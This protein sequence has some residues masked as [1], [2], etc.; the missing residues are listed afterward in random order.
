[1]DKKDILIL[2]ALEMDAETIS[3]LCR[4]SKRVNELICKDQMF[5]RKKL[6]KERP[7]LLDLVSVSIWNKKPINYKQIYA[8]LKM[9]PDLYSVKYTENPLQIY[10]AIQGLLE[11]YDFIQAE[12]E[13]KIMSVGDKV[14]VA[15]TNRPDVLFPYSQIYS[16][17]DSAKR[18]LLREIDFILEEEEDAESIDFYSNELEKSGRTSIGEFNFMMKE[19]TIL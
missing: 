3:K 1:M 5:W 14:W 8:D 7:G 11:D 4:T 18:D 16:S 9:E 19:V 17:K 13:E 6:E 10:G 15:A 2:L 12:S